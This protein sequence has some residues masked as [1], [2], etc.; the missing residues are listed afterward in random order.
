MKKCPYC[1]HENDDTALKCSK[2]KA[3]FPNEET[4]EKSVKTSKRRLNKESE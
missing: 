4:E 1:G 3:D 2:C